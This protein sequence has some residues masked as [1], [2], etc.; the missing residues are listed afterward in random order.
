MIPT[1]TDVTIEVTGR[2]AAELEAV[3]VFL[4]KQTKVETAGAGLSGA[5]RE[6]L[7]Q[8]MAGGA[9]VGKSNEVT[10]QV[11]GEKKPKRLI[12][13]GLGNAEKFSAECLREAGG[14]LA[15]AMKRLRLDS[16]SLVL[17]EIP[18]GLPGV[19]DGKP[20][21]SGREAGVQ[22]IVEGFLLS[23]FDYDEYRGVISRQKQKES[24][25]VRRLRLAMVSDRPAGLKEAV[26]RGRAIAD[27]QN[28]ARTIAS[29]PGNDINPPTLAKVA[30]QFAKEVGLQCRVLDE[31]QMKKLGMGGIL[32]VGGG[33]QKPGGQK[34]SIAALLPRWPLASHPCP[35]S[36]SSARRSRL[37]P[38]GFR[39]SRRIGC[40]G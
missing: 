10:V 26:D 23:S 25:Q 13:V 16:A 14:T 24:R 9:G 29:R 8:V 19:P 32:A 31:K 2:V 12:V 20:L 34:T 4:H 1:S 33:S 28:F 15:R 6:A 40:S 36:S 17:P 35:L 27:G 38:A 21:G 5:A 30:Q 37:T 3:A 39:S 11:Y 22:A 18:A 7:G